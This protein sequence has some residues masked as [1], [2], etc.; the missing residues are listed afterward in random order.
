MSKP[1]SHLF[2]LLHGQQQAETIDASIRNGI[3]FGGANLWVVFFAVLIA[4]VGLNVNSTAVII[5]AMLI[6]PLMGP[7]IGI[8]YG[9][10]VNDF[11][12]IK[13]AFRSLALFVLISLA[14][15]TLYFW[16]SPL[17]DA[18]SELL[19]RTSPSVW[20][21][22]IAFFGGCAGIVALTRK[23]I[24][25]VV[26]GVAIATALMPPLCT[27]G[28][29]L[30]SANMEYFAGAFYLFTINSVFI[31]FSTF[32]FVKLLKLPQHI[33]LDVATQRKT[34]IGIALAVVL[35]VT[36]SG[37]LTFHL[38]QNEVFKRTVKHILADMDKGGEYILLRTQVDAGQRSVELTIGGEKPKQDVAKELGRR[39]TFAGIANANVIVR[40][41]GSERIDVSELRQELQ[42]DVYSNTLK[43]LDERSIQ[44]AS[45][46]GQLASIAR[47]RAD[48]ATVAKEIRALYPE[49]SVVTVARGQS[50][51]GAGNDVREVML[52]SGTLAPDAGAVDEKRL[53][54][55]LTIK[56]PNM[57]VVIGL[58][59]A[60]VAVDAKP[61]PA[62]EPAKQHKRSRK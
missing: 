53:A 17:K 39:L 50:V 24:S 41:A 42:Q 6:S 26:P 33:Q 14:T 12:L 18:Q 56:Y 34:R 60:V 3:L 54:D 48:Q 22:L 15:A 21:V 23:E 30:A 35:T 10:G 29:A 5:G 4:S 52:V 11:A 31:A 61:V 44:V 43:Q 7:I 40:F 20:D 59:A 25:T 46:Q 51:N 36:P 9:A 49:L 2:D 1:L 28:F 19:S 37:Y 62:T 38:L 13:H 57:P 58:A 8:G 16:L 55:W 47:A 45:L 32:L 27:A